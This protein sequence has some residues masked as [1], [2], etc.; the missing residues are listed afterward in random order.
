MKFILE[1]LVWLVATALFVT[2][3]WGFN[4]LSLAISLILSLAI[5][6]IAGNVLFNRSNWS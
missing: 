4:P 3:V 2:S 1:T 5:S 6:M